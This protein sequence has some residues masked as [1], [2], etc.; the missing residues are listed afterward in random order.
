MI[1]DEEESMLIVGRQSEMRRME[2]GFT[3]VDNN[4]NIVLN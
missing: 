2:E 1:R 4:G 3:A